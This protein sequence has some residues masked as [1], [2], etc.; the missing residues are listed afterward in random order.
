MHVEHDLLCRSIIEKL[1][2]KKETIAVAESCSGGLISEWITRI[3]GSSKVFKGGLVAYAN[4]I[5]TQ[6]LGVESDLIHNFGA[7]SSEVAL[8]MATQTIRVFKTD[9]AVSVTGIAGPT[10]GNAQKPVGTV[11]IAIASPKHS[12]FRKCFYEN[13]SRQRVRELSA[14]EALTWLEK[15]L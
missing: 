13:A 7:V 8:A 1:V 3:S 4:E 12:E 11:F 15:K 2:A 10:G 9:W 6:V 14:L 5:K